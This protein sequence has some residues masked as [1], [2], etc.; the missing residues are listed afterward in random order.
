MASLL[1]FTPHVKKSCIAIAIFFFTTRPFLLVLYVQINL[2]VYALNLTFHALRAIELPLLVL[3]L[4]R[5]SWISFIVIQRRNQKFPGP[6]VFLSLPGEFR[7][8]IYTSLPQMDTTEITNAARGQHHGPE[9]TAGRSQ[10]RY[11]SNTHGPIHRVTQSVSG[12]GTTPSNANLL[13]SIE[14]SYGGFPVPWISQ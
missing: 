12:D 8:Q 6:F 11:R 9:A 4:C 14:S 5:S 3:C 7:N 13:R 10:V 1:L 2:R